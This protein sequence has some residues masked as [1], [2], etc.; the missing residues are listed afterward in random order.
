MRTIIFFGILTITLAAC[1]STAKP[2]PD[3]NAF[4]SELND[5]PL[6]PGTDRIWDGIPGKEFP[7]NIQDSHII[8]S[9]TV[10]D[11]SKNIENF[12]S[13]EMRTAGWEIL[14][15]TDGGEMDNSLLFAKDDRIVTISILP[16]TTL[17]YLVVID[18]IIDP[19]YRK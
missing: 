9:Y 2:L 8:Y 11:E 1:A 6:H 17:S 15:K 12:Y 4:P 16:R 3:E 14:G 19:A 7:Q 18:I 10:Q 5:I 13:D